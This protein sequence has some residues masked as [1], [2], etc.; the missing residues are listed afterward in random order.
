MGHSS[1]TSDST[2]TDP[3]LE[4]LWVK[5]NVN[6]DAMLAIISSHFK[7]RCR[8]Q[9]PL[10]IGAFARTF[11][12]SLE[13][14]KE[15][16]ARVT[17][18]VRETV[19]TEAEV[20]TMDSIRARTRIPIPRVYLFCSSQNNPVRAEWIVME[21]MRG[22]QFGKC[23]GD[24]TVE[25]QKITAEDMASVMAQTFSLTATH[26]GSMLFDYTLRNNQRAVR[27][28][29]RA[30]RALQ[31]PYGTIRDTGPSGT[32]IVG[33]AN[34]PILLDYEKPI[35]PSAS[36]PFATE[37]EYLEAVAYLGRPAT[38][39]SSKGQRWAFER[40]LEV[41]EAIRPAYRDLDAAQIPAPDAST[42][43]FAH[44]DLSSSNILLDPKTGHITAVL[45]WE[46]AGFF[47][48][49]HAARAGG[50]FND[51]FQRFLVQ[52]WQDGPLGYDDEPPE[53][54][55]VR[56]HFR[57]TLGSLDPCLFANYWRGVELR[58][59]RAN[60]CHTFPSNVMLWLEKYEKYQWDARQRGPFPFD[61]SKWIDEQYVVWQSESQ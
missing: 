19:K 10:G 49:W 53:A 15:L 8:L 39:P 28:T 50:S 17:L 20:A 48:G 22:I 37:R 57:D 24:L 45:D 11:K 5:A 13:D 27:Y 38:R 30:I 3:E 44:N 54:A 35:P 29:D 41:F 55:D 34:E 21:F 60:L 58:A 9:G 46:M 2:E 59:L 16:V 43:R 42:F 18:P 6:M 23:L 1:H 25:Q 36:G 7:T 51:D 26:C 52:S 4:E 32:F 31:L 56:K 40:V 47:P 14:G 33:P 61:L 12:Y